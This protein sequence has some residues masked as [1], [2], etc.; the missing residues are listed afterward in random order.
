MFFPDSSSAR[1]R[2]LALLAILAPALG[3]STEAWARG[4]LIAAT[5]LLLLA[6]PPRRSPGAGWLALVA[7]LLGLALATFLP[8]TWVP[9]LSW[10]AA[11]VALGVALPGTVTPQPWVRVDAVGTLAAA[12]ALALALLAHRWEREDLRV[13]TRWYGVGM[14]LLAGLAL[15]AGW[16]QWHV[17]WWPATG[18]SVTGF[19]FFPNR[20]Q[21]ANVLALGGIVVMGLAFSDLSRRR[22]TGYLWCAGLLLLGLAVVQT[23]SRAGVG[24]L[25]GGAVGWVFFPLRFSAAKKGVT[26]GFAAALVLVTLFLLFGGRTLERLQGEAG[27]GVD[28]GRVRLQKEAV[29]LADAQP[30]IGYGAGNFE[31]L[32]AITR[33]PGPQQGRA[34]HPESDWVWLAVEMGWPA[35][36]LVVVGLLAWGWQTRPYD[37]G[38]GRYL[39]SAA[40]VGGVAFAVHGLMDASGHRSGALWPALLLLSLARHR[41]WQ[42]QVET[43]WAAPGFRLLG[44][45]LLGLGGWW[46][47][48]AVKPERTLAWP[49][50]ATLRWLERTADAELGANAPAEALRHAEAGTRLEP[51]N[52]LFHYQRALALGGSGG[53]LEEAARAFDRARLLQPRYAQ[54]TMSEGGFWLDLDELPM[55]V[56]SWQETLRRAGPRAPEFFQQMLYRTGRRTEMR[57]ELAAM[58]RP[59][60]ALRVIWLT[61]ADPLDFQLEAAALVEEDPALERLNEA[62]RRE[63]F[64]AWARLGDQAALVEL[65]RAHPEWMADA[66]RGLAGYYA[67]RGDYERAWRFAVE[68]G[69]RPEVP[70]ITTG[71][72]VAELERGFILQQNVLDGLALFQNLRRL[73]QNEEA[74]TTLLALKKL[75]GRPDYTPYVEAELRAER[76]EW[77]LAWEAWSRFEAARR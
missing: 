10:R 61:N 30:W 73:R 66:W 9:L 62:Q 39:R 19:G 75:D 15:G 47:V 76:K 64:A 21:T 3:G 69:P 13:A 5:G 34:V 68:Y 72:S 45:G 25:L 38:S 18:N 74:L 32:F 1:S 7:A 26:L 41:R 20:N 28:G 35:V 14:I 65:I 49:T 56:N 23:H 48:A 59:D 4:T 12:L 50:G 67:R 53:D 33:E 77:Q 42:P 17:P 37:S 60:P 43:R 36:A 8:E 54:M 57:R 31:P 6:L 70:L 16:A 55:V 51:L 46:I 27:W 58:A 29:R 44:L 63:L 11:V 40:A 22:W 24:L 52:W 2:G 71:K